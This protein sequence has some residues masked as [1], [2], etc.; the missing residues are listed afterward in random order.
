M[1]ILYLQRVN[2]RKLQQIVIMADNCFRI[3]E[4]IENV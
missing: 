2:S 4:T 1:Q 3:A